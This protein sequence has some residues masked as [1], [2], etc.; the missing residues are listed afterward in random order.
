MFFIVEVLYGLKVEQTVDRT[1]TG[2]VVGLVHLPTD[3]HSPGSDREGEPDVDTN[4]GASYQGILHAELV[5]K[6]SAYEEN[7]NKRR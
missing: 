1:G 5:P 7:F 6:N 3:P 2:F 4:R